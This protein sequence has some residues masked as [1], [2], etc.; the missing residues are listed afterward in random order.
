MKISNRVKRNIAFVLLLVGITCIIAQAWDVIV[1][2]TSGRA[3]FELFGITVMTYYCL[4]RLQDLQ[5][6]LKRGIK[7]GARR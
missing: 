5:N 4:N 7:F 2:P 1:N 3:W 6:R